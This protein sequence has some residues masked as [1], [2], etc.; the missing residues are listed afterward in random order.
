MAAEPI[1]LWDT[2]APEEKVAGDLPPG[3]ETDVAIIGGGFT[4]LSAALHLARHGVACHVLEAAEIGFGGSGRNAGLVNAGVWLPPQHVR[5]ALGED[6]GM[7][8]IDL[9]GEAPSKVFALI[10][11]YQ[12]RCEATRSGTIH[13]AHARAGLR[14]LAI[15]H[16]EWQRLGAP[17]RLLT[18]GETREK[19]GTDAFHGGLLDE[20]AG[21]INP[22][23][24]VRG[25]ARAAQAEGA[26]ISTGVPVQG[27]E[28]VE[29][30]WRLRTGAGG[31]LAN[32]V[33]IATNAYADALWPGLDRT[34]RKLHYFQIA[35]E[36]LGDRA[37]HILPEGQGL[38]TTG[39]VMIS[40]RREAGGRLLLGSMGKVIGGG[41]GLS[42]AWAKKTL[43]R[44]FPAL[45]D[46]GWEDAWHG[47]LA[48]TPDHLPRIHTPAPGIFVPTGYN[49]RGI[50]TG[51]VFGE[52]LADH[53]A[54]GPEDALPV[55]VTPM[56]PSA[57]NRIAAPA[58]EAALKSYRFLAS[59]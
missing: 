50:T 42:R 47:Q 40:M 28:R 29:D 25:L 59:L 27:F 26:A 15:R 48:M 6:R 14:D 7:A 31:V 23:G 38:W 35:T 20:R 22:M 51:T 43:R 4:G 39:T 44:F 24:Y 12:I 2:T 55:P 49:G 1:S 18:A 10:E 33:I 21:T 8:L 19:T 16:A 46:V 3:L 45:G 32:R 17:V 56:A 5:R 36:P 34:F 30:K 13:A 41:N 52:A 57:L 53:L 9:L 58:Y 54:G 37:R 11:K